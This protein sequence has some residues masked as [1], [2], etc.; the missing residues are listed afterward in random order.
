MASAWFL[1][2]AVVGRIMPPRERASSV[3]NLSTSLMHV[4]DGAC[5]VGLYYTFNLHDGDQVGGREAFWQVRLQRTASPRLNGGKGVA[6]GDPKNDK[7]GM[8]AIL[9]KTPAMA[10][11]YHLPPQQDR[12]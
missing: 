12:N 6:G 1:Q 4:V 9:D 10:K 2:P 11:N 5:G 7:T 8:I 3:G